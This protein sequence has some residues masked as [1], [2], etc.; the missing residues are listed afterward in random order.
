MNIA[1]L[2]EEVRKL[3][4]EAR[5]N[6]DPFASTIGF[7]LSIMESNLKE[8]GNTDSS[9]NKTILQ[10]KKLRKDAEENRQTEDAKFLDSLLPKEIGESEI[11]EFLSE[12]FSN[13]KNI[14]GMM[15]AL[16]E[17]YGAAS[18]DMK[19]ASKIAKD[20]LEK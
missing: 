10:F 4:L 2:I 1:N 14:G 16:K 13:E 15:K 3:F 7:Y 19:L 8:M 12:R 17:H 18:V 11:R 6:K 5:K 20:F 9:Y